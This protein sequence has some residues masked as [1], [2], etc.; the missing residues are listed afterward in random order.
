MYLRVG[1]LAAALLICCASAFSAPQTSAAP[2]AEKDPKAIELIK[3]AIAARGGDRYLSSTSEVG[4]GEFTQFKDGAS[5]IPI[6]FIDYILYPDRER[7]E[8]GKKKTRLVLTNDATSGWTFDASAK[9]L[10]QQT[11]EQVRDHQEGVQFTLDT[12]LKTGWKDPAVVVNYL[13]KKEAWRLQWGETI[14]LLYPGKNKVVLYLSTMNHLPFSIVRDH[15]NP[16]G[17]RVR[18]EDR[19]SQW[20]DRGGIMAPNIID[21]FESDVQ[22]SRIHYSDLD[23]NVAID[24]KIFLMPANIKDVD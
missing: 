12:V 10:K 21:H 22:T 4:R 8:F 6:Q 11:Q 1:R 3:L 5:T 13:G 17:G 9:S 18:E 14:E 15:D 23:Y 2:A 19:F 20:V 7:T 16:D 24:P